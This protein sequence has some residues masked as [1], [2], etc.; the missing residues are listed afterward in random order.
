VPQ[1][2]V[3][4]CSVAAKWI[5]PEPHRAPKRHR[6]KQISEVQARGAYS[7]MLKCAPRLY[8]VR[9]RLSAALEL[10]LQ[11]HLSLWDCVYLA[12]AR[13]HD[14]AVLTADAWLS[15]AVKGSD[16]DVQLVH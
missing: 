12:L 10:A 1:P 5:L 2:F 3:L 13:E 11:K 16:F 14:C 9:P 7:L 8:D 4:D 15:R 6:R